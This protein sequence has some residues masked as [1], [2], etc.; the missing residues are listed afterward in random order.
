MKSMT[1]TNK[2]SIT[3]QKPKQDEILSVSGSSNCATQ[4]QYILTFRDDS[5]MISA[6]L[7]CAGQ[8]LSAEV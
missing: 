6:V 1:K 2:V 5:P 3:T 4:W 8:T 7:S